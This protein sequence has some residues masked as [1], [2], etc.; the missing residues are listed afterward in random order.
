MPAA[1]VDLVS[2]S[3]ASTPP[4]S[5]L[6]FPPIIKTHILHCSYHFWHPLYRSLTPKARLIPLSAPFLAY[7]RADGILLP[8]SRPSS[9]GPTYDIDTDSGIF[10][11]ED[12]D[13]DDDDDQDADPSAAW[14]DIHAAITR[15]IA[16]LGGSVVPKLNW[17]APKDATWI[18]ATNSMECRTPNDVYLLLKSSDFIT[19][20]LEQAFDGCV[21]DPR[22]S[23]STSDTTTIPYTLALRRTI[24][25]II[26]SLE[27]RCFVRQR[28]LLCITQRD[29]NHYDFLPSLVPLLKSLIMTFF[30]EKLRDSFPDENFV[31]DVYIPQPRERG[32]VWLIDVNP[33]AV[34]TD[35]LLFSWLEILTMPDPPSASVSQ[36]LENRVVRLSLRGE[37]AVPPTQVAEAENGEDEAEGESSDDAEDVDEGPEFRLVRRDDP[38]TYSFNT[39]QYS[40]HKLPKDVVDAGVEG[41]AGLRDFMERWRDVVR[42]QGAE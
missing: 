8:P 1:D 42:N 12:S 4:I 21:E 7:L 9:P 19:H 18:S 15:T 5:R 28:T 2:S 13:V 38:E 6:P 30:T 37:G 25:T 41:P 31:F 26:P 34:R 17:S 32:R 23:T 20:D 33:W 40:A 11:A 16:E 10:S 3:G 24:P 14:P 29:L 27:F 36:G 22:T 39:P 35:P